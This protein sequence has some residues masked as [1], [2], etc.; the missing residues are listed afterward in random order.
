MDQPPTAAAALH[1]RWT[2]LLA[3]PQCNLRLTICN[4]WFTTPVP[5]RPTI[6]SSSPVEGTGCTIRSRW[7]NPS[8][9][10]R[11]SPS[12]H[13]RAEGPEARRMIG[14]SSGPAASLPFHP[15]SPP[16]TLAPHPRPHH[17][18][19]TRSVAT[20]PRSHLDCR[21]VLILIDCRRTPSH[22][23]RTPLAVVMHSGFRYSILH[24]V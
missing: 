10:G 8:T 4:P 2:A 18:P 14:R 3:C 21:N 13:A 17:H 24:S 12:V 11:R 1:L 9:S 22:A 7:S 20:P 6:G 15:T 16:P 19:S 5:T 23:S